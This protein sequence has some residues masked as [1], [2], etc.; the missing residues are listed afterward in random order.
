MRDGRLAG[1]SPGGEE[2]QED[3]LA[4]EL[5]EVRGAVVPD[6]R[7]LEG[8][9]DGA[10]GELGRSDSGEEDRSRNRGAAHGDGHGAG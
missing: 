10:L 7:E 2:L 4:G 6:L 8:R 1:A 9:R 5:V 3:E